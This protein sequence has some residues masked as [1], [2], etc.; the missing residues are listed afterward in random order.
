LKLEEVALHFFGGAGSDFIEVRQGVKESS[1]QWSGKA[2]AS[3]LEGGT[4]FDPM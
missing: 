3:N 1:L 4:P 2:L